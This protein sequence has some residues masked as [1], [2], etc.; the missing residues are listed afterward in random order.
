VKRSKLF[1]ML[2]TGLVSTTSMAATPGNYC[3]AI[4]GNGELM[5]AHWG[6]MSSIVEEQGLP[7]AM[8][9]G[10]SASI[11]MFLL[12]S[13]S[14][15]PLLKNNS[16]TALMIKSFQGYFE[17]LTQTEEGKSLQSL[18]AD[19]AAFQAIL[20]TGGK[21]EEALKNPASKALLEKHLE[22][23]KILMA[24]K[25]L[26]SLINPDFV[27][28]VQRTAMLSNQTDP[29]VVAVYKYRSGQISHALKNFGKFNAQTDKT[30]FFRPSLINFGGL[31]QNLGK[32]ADF[33]ANYNNNPPAGKQ[34][35]ERL[36]QFLDACTPGTQGLSW[37]EINEQRP[38]CRQL[39]GSAV[40]MY[41]AADTGAADRKSRVDELVGS[42]IP[43]YATTSVLTG[44]AVEKYS[45]M[46]V[47]YQKNADENFG[48]QLTIS[49]DDL[50]FGYWGQEADLA[51]VA[52]KFSSESL[53]KND[54]KSQ[55]FLS[56]GE[57]PWSDVLAMSPAEPG[58][59]RIVAI[60]REQLSAGGW[61]D[62]H[63]TLILK[64]HGCENIIYVTRKGE[65]SKFAQGI[66]K[67]LTLADDQTWSQF[68]DM[69]NSQSSI[70]RSYQNATQIKCTSWDLFD[71]KKD[72]NGLVEEAMHAPLVKGGACK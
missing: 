70:S 27:V 39:L 55:K 21:I 20:A 62:L 38:V 61:S 46:F 31:S 45:Q 34:I 71:V 50:K 35:E 51:N 42:H 57:A 22:S 67:R 13:L 14:L 7:S 9:G 30:L 53:Y 54:A 56:L 6:A 52:N 2:L 72:M 3:A 1:S 66:F 17:A 36:R 69:N 10:S 11:T 26:K 43:A 49:Q 12:E 29:A 59:S 28:Y 48:D 25:D 58:L 18:F 24:S 19:K 63:P 5:P 64:A 37:R 16:E 65:E 60:N 8:A 41:R 44:A 68:Y 32:M 15:N 40:L 23:L 33:Y 4:R 47:E